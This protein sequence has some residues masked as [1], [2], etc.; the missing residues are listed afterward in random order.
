MFTVY[1]YCILTTR[2]SLLLPFFPSLLEESSWRLEGWFSATT[3]PQFCW[4]GEHQL[5][6]EPPEWT[7]G[8]ER[9]CYRHDEKV[10]S[11]LGVQL[12]GRA[13]SKCKALVQSLALGRTWILN[14]YNSRK[15]VCLQRG[16]LS[17]ERKPWGLCPTL[18]N[19]WASFL[20]ISI[21]PASEICFSKVRNN[22]A[23]IQQG[24]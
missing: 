15:P 10:C 11:S 24:I 22:Q 19:F 12:S 14:W 6:S 9:P 17:L 20:I 2:Y 23:T 18:A 3:S 7:R 8:T 5:N 4:W 21:L 13:L 1:T 16:A